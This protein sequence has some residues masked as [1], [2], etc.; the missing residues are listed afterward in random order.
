MLVKKVWEDMDLINT[1]NKEMQCYLDINKYAFTYTFVEMAQIARIS[2]R[3]AEKEPDPDK[4]ERLMAFSDYFFK[5]V[6]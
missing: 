2:C 5:V 6:T 3:L 4:K 1:I